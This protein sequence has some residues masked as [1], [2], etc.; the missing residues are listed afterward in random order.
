MLGTYY[1]LHYFLSNTKYKLKNY[2]RN[3]WLFRKALANTV[4]WD[5]SGLLLL[6]QTQIMLLE[7]SIRIHGHHLNKDNHCKRMRECVHLLDRIIKDDYYKADLIWN[8]PT[9]DPKWGKVHTIK[10]VPLYDYPKNEK[11]IK[12]YARKQRGKDLER[13][14]FLLNKHVL[15]WWD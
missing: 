14:T 12:E 8:E 1:K 7:E 10:Q 9:L 2:F 13:L 3:I 15:S 4:S 11:V 6:M 5:Y